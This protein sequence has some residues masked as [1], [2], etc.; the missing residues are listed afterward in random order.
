MA[1]AGEERKSV[2]CCLAGC[3]AASVGGLRRTDRDHPVPRL[4]ALIHPRLNT[5]KGRGPKETY[6]TYEASPSPTISKISAAQR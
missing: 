6:K 4:C 3:E 5:W 1:A 2:G